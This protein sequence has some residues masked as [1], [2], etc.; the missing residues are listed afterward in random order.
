MGKIGTKGKTALKVV[1]T[2][3]IQFPL[4]NVREGLGKLAGVEYI[5]KP[6]ATE[7]AIIEAAR[8]ADVAVVMT[9]PYTRQVI[10][11]LKTC[12]LICTPK[13]GYDNIDIEAATEAGICVSC[14]LTASIEEVSDHIM[15][16]LLACARRIPRLNNAVRE[17]VWKALHGP[18]MEKIWQGIIPM[19]GQTLGIIGFGRIARALVPKATGFGLRILAYDSNVE[20]RDTKGVEAATL[21]RLIKESDFISINCALTPENRHMLGAE[22]FKQMKSSAILINTARG[23]LVD[24]EAL[25][26]ALTGG[27]IA[28]AGLDVTSVEPINMDNPLLKL[29][30]VILTGHSAHYSDISAAEVRHK[31]VDDVSMI[32]SGKWP[33]GWINTEVEPKYIARWGKPEKTIE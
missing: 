6:S 8:E 4:K 15:A 27:E 2:G 31:V 14:A 20:I 23:A 24:E 17:G 32:I 10:S 28:G 18:E 30:N 3:I 11:N 12:R 13:M 21:E 19:R 22:Q 1:S 16:L 5:D 26:Y 25:Y 9:E 7:E 33:K 29:D